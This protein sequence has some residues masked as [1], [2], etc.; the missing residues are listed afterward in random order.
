MGIASLPRQLDDLAQVGD[1]SPSGNHQ[2]ASFEPAEQ[3]V[4]D[5]VTVTVPLEDCFPP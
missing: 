5:L 1:R 3:R 4:V 2:P